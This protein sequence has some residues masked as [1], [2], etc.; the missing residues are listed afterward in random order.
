MHRDL[1]NGKAVDWKKLAADQPTGY[2]VSGTYLVNALW[3]ANVP[4]TQPAELI[5]PGN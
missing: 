5:A 3:R 2:P 1:E 4:A